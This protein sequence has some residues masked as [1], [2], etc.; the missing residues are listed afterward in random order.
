MSDKPSITDLDALKLYQDPIAP[1][2]GIIIAC[3]VGLVMWAVGWFAAAAVWRLM[4]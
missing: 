4:Q 3:V 1:A 2:R